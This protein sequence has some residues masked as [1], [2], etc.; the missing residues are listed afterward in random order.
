MNL[1]RQDKRQR[2]CAQ[3]F[4]DAVRD[5]GASPIPFEEIIEVSRITVEIAR[6]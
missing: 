1:R 3:A 5:G 6:K 4:V 2:A